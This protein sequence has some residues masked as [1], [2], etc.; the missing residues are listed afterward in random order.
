MKI[1]SHLHFWNYDAVKDAWI[2][3][4]MDVLKNDYVPRQL[5]PLCANEGIDAGVAVQADQSE[6]ETEY[7]VGFSRE[8]NF[9][10]GVVGWVDLRAQNISDRLDYFSQ[11]HIV[12]GYRHIIQAEAQE[13]FLLRA[14][15][16]SGI[17]ELS[18][19]G[20]T[21]DVLIYPRHL[22]YALDFVRKF[23]DLRL[24]IDHIA[25]PD[26]RGGQ[27]E[28]WKKA[29]EPFGKEQNVYCKIAG[30]TTQ[31]DWKSWAY[32]DFTRYLDTVL[33]IFGADRLMFGSDWPVC[34]V[35]ADYKQTCH[36]L[37]NY[38]EQLSKNEQKK[39]WG[40]NCIQFYNLNI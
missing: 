4:E 30:L 6:N 10:K 24:V 1:D 15:F 40:E 23:P 21:Y 7:L 36:V 37:A 39:I 9:I 33:S 22:A 34:L 28:D 31:A 19:R 16:C 32:G 38:I 3:D 35:G 5:L 14:D 26:I 20:L 11:Y 18:R 17:A 2:T 8:F 27:F 12:K 25:K 13:D 29:L